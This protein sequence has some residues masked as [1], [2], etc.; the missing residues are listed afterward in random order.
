MRDST[1]EITPVSTRISTPQS[2]VPDTESS[3]N[4]RAAAKRTK[5]ELESDDAKRT[6]WVVERGSA[7]VKIYLTPHG[8]EKYYTIS[9]WMDGKRHRQLF[10]TLQEAK[11]A[12][13][14]KATKMTK[15]D[16]G[17]AQL[18][19]A[20]SAA[21]L[22]AIELLK[23]SGT[24]LEFAASEYASAI[25][26][27]GAVSLSQAVDF[28][29]K[30]HPVHMKPKKVREVVDELMKGKEGDKLSRRYLRQ[31]RYD[32]DR[33]ADRFR[34]RLGDVLGADID[35]WLRSLQVGPRTRNNL[36]NSVQTLF[37][38]AIGRR[39]LPTDHDE[40]N[41]VP[42]VKD[43]D[44]EIEIFTPEEMAEILAAGDKNAVPFLAMAAFAGVRHAELERLEWAHVKRDASVIEIKA[45]MAKTA[46]RRV[47]P[48]LPNL[49]AWLEDHW[50]DSGKVSPYVNMVDEIVEVTRRVNESRR[51]AWAKKHKV[52]KKK[53][54][55]TLAAA[56]KRLA[57]ERKKASKQGGRVPMF[58]GCE[59]AAE[60]GWT[61]FVWKHNA[62]RHSFISYRV[63][64]IQNVAQ[65]ALEAGNSPGMIFKHYRELVR[66][67]DAERW[68]AIVPKGKP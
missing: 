61:P 31:L 55:A 47:I 2:L 32:M 15:G 64:Q 62:L 1:L 33:F 52:G 27:L 36:R 39:Y 41:A 60:E 56:R 53:L 49:A 14:D 34:G 58:P 22:R 54:A 59:T 4:P 46:S 25:K 9:Y 48:L 26:R 13:A 20:D 50:K 42:V 43:G 63:A 57:A 7:V 16:L 40:L 51:A 10:K 8:E 37:N 30:R 35:E 45:G 44:G 18:T 38:F 3:A 12:A 5:A 19:N 17:A 65:V 23:P 66:P 21:Y 6:K 24:P 11:D 29:L 28:Y 68:F 67:A